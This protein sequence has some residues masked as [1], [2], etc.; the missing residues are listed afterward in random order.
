MNM[1]ESDSKESDSKESNSKES[2]L[3]FDVTQKA[4]LEHLADNDASQDDARGRHLGN[5]GLN[6]IKSTSTGD[7]MKPQGEHHCLW[8][9]S[10]HEHDTVYAV[11]T[12]DNSRDEPIEKSHWQPQG[13]RDGV[14]DV[15]QGK[16][17]HRR[18]PSKKKRRSKP[19]HKLSWEEKRELDERQSERAIRIR[20][21][22]FAKGLPV[23]PYNT[24]QFIMEEH[25]WEEPN[26][27][28]ISEDEMFYYKDTDDQCSGAG[29]DYIGRFSGQEFLERDF[30]EMYEKYHMESLHNMSKEELVQ[31]Y[32][33][34]ER[35]MSRLEEEN[36]RLRLTT[37]SEHVR[38]LEHKLDTLWAK[39]RTTVLAEH[40]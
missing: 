15:H 39:T 33:E 8:C 12:Q 10:R 13:D 34:L 7:K 4:S 29:S 30:S 27:N 22:M 24:T 18:R 40:L 31:E 37:D 20:T 1:S 23:A 19:Y 2:D 11:N 25:E 16:K 21:E 26:L 35:C 3:Y 28:T 5:Q 14:T 9:S 6:D 36:R 17:K 38:V 32:L